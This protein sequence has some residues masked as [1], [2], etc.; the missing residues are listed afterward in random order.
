MGYYTRVAGAAAAVAE[1]PARSSYYGS[2]VRQHAAVGAWIA[3]PGWLAEQTEKLR[4][5]WSVIGKEIQA[6]YN[7]KCLGVGTEESERCER[8][9]RFRDEV[10]IPMSAR[11]YKFA[12]NHADASY[13]RLI[14]RN[15]W[16]SVWDQIK[17]WR[18]QL[19]SLRAQ[20][21]SA[22]YYF[23]SPAVMPAESSPW[24]TISTFLKWIVG[25]LVGFAAVY[26]VTGLISAI[27]G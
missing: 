4:A 2:M 20:A 11:F 10:W 6:E 7:E 21:E 16:G 18:Q 5:E 14:L 9:R 27:K 15:F 23:Q 24:D 1:L 17:D 13:A 26:A 8:M 22:G 25:A 3:T 12:A 19:I